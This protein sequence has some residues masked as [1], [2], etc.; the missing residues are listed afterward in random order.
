MD[1]TDGTMPVSYGGIMYVPYSV[2]MSGSLRIYASYL[3]TGE[4]ALF[5]SS[6]QIYFDV[7]GGGCRDKNGNEYTDS[8]IT[9]NGTTYVP[10]QFTADFFGLQYSYIDTT[11]GGM[12]RIRS[13]S[14][15]LSD[16]VFADAAQS[17]M[18]S[19]LNEYNRAHVQVTA[20]PK[21]TA[22]P[23]PSPTPT[24]Y[25]RV[26]IS[27]IF[28]GLSDGSEAVLKTLT[29]NSVTACFF[30][31]AD[32]IRN[33]PDLIR[34]IEGRGHTIGI[35]CQS[36]EDFAE[37]AQLLYETAKIKADIAAVWGEDPGDINARVW[38]LD[39]ETAIDGTTQV[40]R[41]TGNIS[42][43]DYSRDK[44]VFSPTEEAADQ[45]SDIIRYVKEVK[46]SILRINE[47]TEPY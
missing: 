15:V 47:L 30:V 34:E 33:Y 44:L 12:V 1:L 24:T 19:K 26:R 6:K 10:A 7:S 9:R 4:L 2:F 18:R 20:T 43:E 45:L 22:T 35:L 23:S 8:A 11:Y 37:T 27:F 16:A 17:A 31:T 28:A 42:T 38:V 25:E 29:S 21:P 46:Y 39:A 3:S 36:G 41:I 13:S 32:D 40:G 14:S 5:T